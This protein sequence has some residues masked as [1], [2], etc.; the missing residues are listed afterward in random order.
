MAIA[1]DILLP[2]PS[3][4]SYAP[5]ARMLG[6]NVVPVVASVSD[7]GLTLNADTLQTAVED[8]RARGLNPT[9]L[10]INFPG[11]PT[12]ITISES[13]LIS[14]AAF[15][16]DN[17]ITL[18]SDEIYG[19][20]SFDRLYRTAASHSPA[21]AIVSTGLSKHLSLGG[22]RLGVGLVPKAMTGLIDHLNNVASETWS[23]V[24][25]PIQWAAVEAY[26]GHDRCLS[27]SS[28]PLGRLP[29]GH[30]WI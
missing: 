8:A 12:G 30:P 14:I 20:L 1:G 11:N 27:M 24:S 18:I 9:K 26:S 5:Q 28:Y 13:Q 2:V 4:V 15:C 16:K 25:T 21:G 29:V 22:W 3:W 17:A 10:L 23:C 19:R 7:K 6:Q